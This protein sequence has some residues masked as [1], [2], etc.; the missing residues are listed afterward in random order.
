MDESKENDQMN[1]SR[2]KIAFIINDMRIGG[3][4][5]V[6]SNLTLYFPQDWNIDII[7]SDASE[8]E[9]P[10][11]GNI[12]DLGIK[13]EEYPAVIYFLKVLCKRVRILWKFKREKRYDACIGFADSA[14]IANILSGNKVC[15]VISAVHSTLSEASR[16][17]D[18]RYIVAPLVKMLYNKSDK[19]VAVSRG[20]KD[21]LIKNY[22]IKE[23]KI[24]TIYNGCD[25]ESINQ[26]MQESLNEPGGDGGINKE[27]LCIVT[28]GRMDFPKA[29]WHLIRAFRYVVKKNPDV[30]LLI[31]GAGE[32]EAYLR[33]LAD[34]LNLADSVLF[35]GFQENPFQYLG[36]CHLF[37]FPSLYEGFP[38]ALIEAMYCGLPVVATD[39][40]TGAREVLAPDLKRDEILERQVIYAKYGVLTP[41]CDGTLYSAKDSLT[42]EEILLADAINGLLNNPGQREE[43][44]KRGREYVKQ[45]STDRMASEWKALVEAL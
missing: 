4:E 33:R 1:S 20:I 23:N 15:R 12:I 44:S 35:M 16:R 2:K 3:S 13:K 24:V 19:V 30:K 25:F 18:Y 36:R 7:L 42:E 29:Q 38:N 11:R 43:Y 10:Y 27:D 5:R 39:F 9:Y 28:M 40:H 26:K 14:N 32:L 17:R 45:F 34:E 21:D 6:L 31:L 22:G 41:V 37:A 8:I